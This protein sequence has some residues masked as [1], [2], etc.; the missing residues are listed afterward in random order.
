MKG[1]SKKEIVLISA[2]EFDKKYFFT[3]A[4]VDAFAKNKTERYNLIKHLLKKRRIV[5]LNK[6][7]YFLVPIQAKSGGW[8]ENLYLTVDEIMDGK[9]YVIGGWAAAN[10][11]RLTDQI[12][13]QFDVYTT[14]RQGKITLFHARIVFHR[15]TPGKVRRGVVQMLSNHP[16]RIISKKDMRKWIKSRE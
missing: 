11:W 4:D 14:K 9:D 5:K 16:F 1:I 3:S 7:K 2:L 15:T 8:S 10:Y 6:H 12:P 13:F